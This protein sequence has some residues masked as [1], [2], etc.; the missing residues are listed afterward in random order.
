MSKKYTYANPLLSL[1]QSAAEDVQRKRAS[2]HSRLKLMTA[3]AAAPTAGVATARL[4]SG[5]LTAMSL[6]SGPQLAHRTGDIPGK[7]AV[8]TDSQSVSPKNLRTPVAGE[9]IST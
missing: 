3:S 1:W 8:S 7:T 6:E 9:W 5:T 4:R 2:T